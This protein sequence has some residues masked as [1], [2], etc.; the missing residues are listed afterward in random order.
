MPPESRESILLTIKSFWTIIHLTFTSWGMRLLTLRVKW[1]HM[2]KTPGSSKAAYLWLQKLHQ[3]VTHRSVALNGK[4]RHRVHHRYDGMCSGV[5]HVPSLAL[6]SV[7]SAYKF[8]ILSG[9]GCYVFK[10]QRLVFISSL[11]FSK[12]APLSSANSTGKSI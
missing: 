1:I 12:T 5:S 4:L 11:M 7:V 8:I 2:W 9:S 3:N 6:A 10:M